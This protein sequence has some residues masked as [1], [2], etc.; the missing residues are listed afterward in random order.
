[1]RY[2][3][4]CLSLFPFNNKRSGSLL[5]LQKNYRN[6]KGYPT[7]F[8]FAFCNTN[9]TPTLTTTTQRYFILLMKM[10]PHQVA[11]GDVGTESSDQAYDEKYP[12]EINSF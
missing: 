7:T 6:A 11:H 3:R 2:Q 4:C 9:S 12:D 10:L 1:M 5:M 8:A